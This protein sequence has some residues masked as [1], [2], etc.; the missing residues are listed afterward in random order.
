[1]AWKYI[2]GQ[3]L[4]YRVLGAP[5]RERSPSTS[6]SGEL[7]LQEV[8]THRQT[9]EYL[10]DWQAEGKLGECPRAASYPALYL[11]WGLLPV[12]PK[13]K[14]VNSGVGKK[15]EHPRF[16]LLSFSSSFKLLQQVTSKQRLEGCFRLQQ[17]VT[18]QKARKV[19]P[20]TLCA[21]DN[22]PYKQ[23]GDSFEKKKKKRCVGFL[24][25]RVIFLPNHNL[26]LAL[27]KSQVYVVLL[28]YN[29][30]QQ[31]HKNLSSSLS[32]LPTT[33]VGDN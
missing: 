20:E 24:R 31:T 28:L 27:C 25:V 19:L 14:T 10:F 9:S 15:L 22:I 23:S 12:E 1:M 33:L 4:I 2:V 6:P 13:L 11:V 3:L 30:F 8:K 18:K 16:P 32:D 29:L 26:S 7:R 5:S 21:L 17:P